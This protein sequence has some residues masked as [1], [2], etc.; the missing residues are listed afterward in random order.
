MH[1]DLLGQPDQRC[2][3]T[4]PSNTLNGKATS[5]AAKQLNPLGACSILS[6]DLEMDSD[7]PRLG[8]CNSGEPQADEDEG[9]IPDVMAHQFPPI[10]KKAFSGMPVGVSIPELS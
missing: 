3:K 2:G 5:V 8:A 9:R 1:I 6:V 4:P 10:F 7:L